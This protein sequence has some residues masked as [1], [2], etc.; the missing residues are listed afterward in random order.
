MNDLRFA[1]RQLAKSPGFTTVA[2][3]MLAL[4][5]GLSTSSFSMANAFLLR[6]VPYPDADRLVRIFGTSR[7]TQT[8]GLAPGN[9]L[10]LRDTATSFSAV[11][12]YNGDNYSLG[13]PGQPAE[14]VFGMAATANFFDLLGVR[15]SLGRGFVTGEDQPGKPAVAVLSYR[16]WVRRYAGDPGVI[17]R[18]IRINTQPYTI[19]GVLP[20]TFEAPIVWGP[21]E[22]VMPRTIE[23]TFRTN[24]TDTWMQAV[25]R[26]KPGVSP[27]QAQTEL[28]TLAAR[29]EQAYPKENKGRG[30]SVVGLAQSNMD[31]VSRSLL[32]L[33]TGIA[34]AMLLIACANLA[35]LQVARAFGRSREF[36]IRAALGGGRR[37]LMI[38]L[39]VESVVLAL[40]GGVLSLLVASWSNE[41]I[42]SMLLI[43]NEPG[44]AI[45]LDGRV[46]AFAAISSLLSGLAFGL[47][48]AWLASRAPAAEAL[49]EGS[50]S[51][52]S[53]PSHQRLKRSLIVSELALAL[54]LVGVAGAFGVGAKTFVHRQVG[55]N[56]DGLFTGYLALPYNPYGDNAR[57]RQFYRALQPKLAALPGVQHAAISTN[58]PMYALGPTVPLQIE[59]QPVEEVTRRPLTQVGTVTSD[60]FVALQIPLK[61]GAIFSADV[62]EKDPAVAVVNEAFARRF[63]PDGSA[64][65]R[66]V[67]LG[68]DQ[69]WLEVVGVVGDV[70]MLGRLTAL[71]TPLQLY[72]PLSQNLTRYVGLVLRT[73]VTPESLT[74][75]VREAV[76]ALDADLPVAQPGSLRAAYERN[77]TNLNLVI[78]NLAI[79]AGMGLL[80]AAVGLFG[81]I[82]QLTAQRTRDIGVR[83]ALGASRG[84]ILRLILGEGVRLL[85]IGTAIGIP[86][87]YALTM[88]LR[89]A[90]PAMQLPGLWLLAVNVAVLCGHDAA[91]L[92]AA[93]PPGDAHQPGR[94]AAIRVKQGMRDEGE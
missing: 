10:D 76:A 11:A 81:V 92:L 71:D 41:I 79:S 19:I 67:R 50:R 14:Q 24:R 91:G 47:A 69:Q 83:I 38:P 32:W 49:K 2:V 77:L 17:G 89:G 57:S 23:T 15:P 39:L 20:A 21:V 4:G 73:S 90:L 5:I 52:T 34:L 85:V 42:G 30:L 82:S 59:G 61:Q 37:Q 88:I 43:N 33:M 18:T 65:G 55:W 56:M 44:Y 48:P 58:L 35:S 8:G 62:T 51:S 74:K 22:F 1:F 46:F 75:S 12:L 13:E 31:S 86:A 84:D 93:R 36:A 9:A 3:L 16:A 66:R 25:A 72:R 53:G 6:N 40:G 63:W 64:V 68:D 28:A 29:L 27:R 54:A 80:I 87:Y 78:V 60:F 94:G 70:G 26:L 7:Q 45:P